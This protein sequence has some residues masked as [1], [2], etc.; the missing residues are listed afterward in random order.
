MTT[1]ILINNGKKRK[2]S[3]GNFYLYFQEL[4]RIEYYHD[5]KITLEFTPKEYK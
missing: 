1:Y 4:P 2:V 3:K 5:V